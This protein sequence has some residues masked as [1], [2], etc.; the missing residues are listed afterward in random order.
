MGRRNRSQRIV[1]VIGL[2]TA[3]FV[4]GVYLS[5]LGM[6]YGWIAYAPLSR[7][8]DPLVT[9]RLTPLEDLFLWLGL[10]TLWVGA[11]VFLLRHSGTEDR[12]E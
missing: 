10:V 1:A 6:F 2:G 9:P 5:T 3:L 11:A 7:T 8:T 4:V 12:T